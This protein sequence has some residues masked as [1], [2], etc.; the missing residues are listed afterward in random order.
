M[1]DHDQR[2]SPKPFSEGPDHLA[3][4]HA[5]QGC[6]GFVEDDEIG[7]AYQ[8]PR[9]SNSLFLPA[10]KAHS[11]GAQFRAQPGGQGLEEVIRRHVLE[12][13]P[14]H[15]VRERLFETEC[16]VVPKGAVEQPDVLTYQ[17][18]AAMK[19]TQLEF[20][21]VDPVHQDA[22]GIGVV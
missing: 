13:I 10:R 17:R 22:A 8:G 7:V 6:S 11:A 2:A 16:E 18:N 15:V 14:E 5:V 19:R 4:Q 12:G 9:Q 1:R 20:P 3:L 21:D